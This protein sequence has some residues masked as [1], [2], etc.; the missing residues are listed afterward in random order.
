MSDTLQHHGIPGQKWGIRRYQNGDGSLTPAGRKRAEKLKS[1]FKALTGKK[2][3]GKIDDDDISKKPIR[4]L[5]DTDL[6]S[7]ITRL[8]NEREA[9]RLQKEVNEASSSKGSKFFRTLGKEV[10]APS[11]IQAGKT[12]L[13]N[14]LTKVATKA[15]G[16]D[17]SDI[18]DAE[19]A[20]QDLKRE[21]QISE[22]KYK[23]YSNDKKLRK[24]Q[25]AD[26]KSSNESNKSNNSSNKSSKEPS[27][28]VNI[29]NIKVD[30]SDVSKGKK[31]FDESPAKDITFY[32]KNNSSTALL[33]YKKNG[34]KLFDNLYR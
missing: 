16:L 33:P 21:A 34:K 18:S 25:E 6:N 30:K 17:K 9:L 24:E 3:K 1:E 14:Y 26:N 8:S 7:R 28:Q 11:A 32:D 2:L 19:K 29:Y 4:K 12:V 27:S 31:F 5:S 13:T 22:F 23:K 20:F 15:M 10:I